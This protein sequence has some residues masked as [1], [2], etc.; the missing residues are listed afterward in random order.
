MSNENLTRPKFW[1]GVIAQ[2]SSSAAWM[3]CP[4]LPCPS[5]LLTAEWGDG[6]WAHLHQPL[7]AQQ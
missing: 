6:V 7:G 3:S 5:G 4:S 2:Q 1:F